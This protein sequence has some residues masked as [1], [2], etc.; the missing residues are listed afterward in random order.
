MRITDRQLRQMIRDEAAAL[1]ESAAVFTPD[2]VAMYGAADH[3]L[4]AIVALYAVGKLRTVARDILG[5]LAFRLQRAAI[6]AANREAGSKMASAVEALSNDADLIAL[7]KELEE[8][9]KSGER[10][11]SAKISKKSKEI[12]AYIKDKRKD[13]SFGNGGV[14]DVRRDVSKRLKKS[15]D[16]DVRKDTDGD[17]EKL[18]EAHWARQLRQIVRQEVIREARTLA[19]PPELQR[20]V[21]DLGF[22]VVKSAWQSAEGDLD[23][24]V[25]E[26]EEYMGDLRWDR[27][28]KLPPE[29]TP[30]VKAL[31]ADR[32]RMSWVG[33]EGDLDGT[34]ADLAGAVHRRDMDQMADELGVDLPTRDL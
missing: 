6:D 15:D 32:V 30:Y 14:Q 2:Q 29:L 1:R 16:T 31:G 5:G 17:D 21:D 13:M 11:A 4:V 28:Q 24:A 10:G 18:D 33:N 19:F 8:L 34:V 25:D 3:V 9:Q 27:E 26:L 20:Y 23:R 7:F 22:W 12:T